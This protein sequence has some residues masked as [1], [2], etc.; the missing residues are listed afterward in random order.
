MLK[1]NKRQQKIVNFIKNNK[2]TTNKE[3]KEYISS[4]GDQVSRY[5]ILRD[6]DILIEK[7]LIISDGRGRGVKYQETPKIL[8]KAFDI[9]KYFKIEP[10]KREAKKELDFNIFNDLKKIDIFTK[11]EL[12]KLK[13]LTIKFQKNYKELSKAIIKREFERLT[14]E[15][16]W[17]SSQIEG[18]TYDILETEFLIKEKQEAKG[19]TKYEATMILNHKK[20][21]DYINENKNEFNKISISNIELVHNLL[22]EDL[23]I[24]KGFREKPVGIG[25]TIYRPLRSS[26]QIRQALESLCD[27]VNKKNDYYSK[28]LLVN[29]LIAYIQPFNDGNK[30]TSRLMGNAILMANN[31]CPLSF[32]SVD[33]LDYKKAVLLFYEQNNLSYFKELFIEQFEFAVNN[34]F[35]A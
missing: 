30:R 3:I 27:L 12:D 4:V 8:I 13:N 17:K 14:I 28:A 6:L 23:G 24:K 5:T 26:G 21:I 29:I 22:S 9:N 18:N 25:G 35:Q 11:K 31:S 10:D 19:H 2:S 16:S 15:L 34:Y 20:A 7:N 33:V 1:L 32:R